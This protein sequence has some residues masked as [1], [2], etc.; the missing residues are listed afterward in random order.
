MSEGKVTTVFATLA[1]VLDASFKN[2]LVA[3]Q[4]RTVWRVASHERAQP[5]MYCN[6]L[7]NEDMYCTQ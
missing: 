2:Y 3:A 4:V 7:L 6:R 5:L 1:E